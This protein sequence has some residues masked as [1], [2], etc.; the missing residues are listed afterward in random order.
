MSP[1]IDQMLLRRPAT[2]L[3]A[4]RDLDDLQ[5]RY[6]SKYV[7]TV[8]TAA[9]MVDALDPSW[10]V[11]E[12]AGRRSTAYH[13]S[14]FDDE[15]FGLF[16]DHVKGRRLRYKVRTRQYEND[17]AEMLEIKLKLG[18]GATDKRR[19]TR[20][21]SISTEL[22]TAERRWVSDMVFDAYGRRLEGPL[23]FALGLGY[24]RRTMFNPATGERLTIDTDL[25]AEAEGAS[26]APVG[27]AVVIEVKG[28]H[29][30]G[31]TVRLLQRRSVRTL[32]FSKYC[33][34]LASLYPDLDQR[35]R[36]RAQRSFERYS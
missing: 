25:V 1:S 23:A 17:P 7:V 4:I 31:P 6:E 21:G 34:A 16:R 14:Y 26:T 35:A 18:R 27:E 20:T 22:T 12:V 32:T 8:A 36:H 30:Y 5:E 10:R 15:N 11:L 29:W 28:V 2:N 33:A 19:V 13:S 9:D 3:E 24:T